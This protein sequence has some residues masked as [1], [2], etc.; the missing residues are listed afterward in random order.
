MLAPPE[1]YRLD[2]ARLF[3]VAVEA[4]GEDEKCRRPEPDED[5]ETLG[6]RLGFGDLSA[7][8]KPDG[9]GAEDG[10][11]AEDEAEIAE[12]FELSR[13]HNGALM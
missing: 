3:R 8:Q 2:S 7:G 5:A 10:G 11:K 4:V 12:L 1:R 6:V 13:F 9:D